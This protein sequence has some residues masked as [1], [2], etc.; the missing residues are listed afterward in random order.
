MNLGPTYEQAKVRL[1]NSF[2]IFLG[3]DFSKKV[4]VIRNLFRFK[5]IKL[6]DS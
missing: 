3:K 5:S 6:K 1:D 2:I 4:K